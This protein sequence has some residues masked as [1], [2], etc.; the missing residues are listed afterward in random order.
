MIIDREYA[1]CLSYGSQLMGF[2]GGG[3]EQD[4][5][6]LY[7]KAFSI[8]DEN[9]SKIELI[10]VQELIERHPEGGMVVTI[11]G[12][13]SPAS[14]TAY[15]PTE[16]YPRLME[17][18]DTQLESDQKIVGFISCEIGASS[19][20]EPFIPAAMTCL[21][22]I[23]AP[24]DGRAHPLGLMGALGL[25]KKGFSVIQ[26][27]LGGKK[28]EDGKVGDYLEIAV[29]A[30]VESAAAL[31]RNAAAAAGG[32]VS[33]ARNPVDLDWLDKNSAKGA[34]RQAYELGSTW[35]AGLESK[36]SA[37]KLATVISELLNGRVI[38]R[39]KL[40]NYKCD[41]ANAL[42]NG[43]FQIADSTLGDDVEFSFFN[44]YMTMESMSDGKR[45][46]TFPDGMAVIG[47]SD[48]KLYS[49]AMLKDHDGEAF[50][51][52]ATSHSN[53]VIPTGLRYRNS[54][55]KVE[56]ILK[57]SMISYLDH[58]GFFLD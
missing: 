23:D 21:P 2:G 32:A 3:G 53:L 1:K 19:S 39:G 36:T 43:S 42:D 41:T 18:L 46:Y 5:I 24:C 26:V 6:D 13:G 37:A 16:Y 20:F 49:S 7:E 40:I 8:A 11:S 12:V 38:C 45:K 56:E 29:K 54:Y 58:D 34:Y 55:N 52:I 25:E 35:K 48:M 50:Y 31:I 27:G 22:I 17:L 44:E 9:G 15:T 28:G 4:G 33:V 10:S 57:K 14:E 47:E 51:V 30:S